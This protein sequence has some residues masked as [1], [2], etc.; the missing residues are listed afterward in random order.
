MLFKLWRE[1]MPRR[2][3]FLVIVIIAQVVQ[4]LASLW[5]PTLNADIINDGIVGENLALIW[6]LGGIMLVATVIQAL[7]MVVSAYFSGRIAMWIGRDVRQKV[8][9]QVLTFSSSQMHRFGSA[10]LITRATN[11]INQ[12]QS[13]IL[14]TFIIMIQAPIMG[15]GAVIMAVSLD[16][17]LS[18]L[19]LVAVPVLLAVVGILMHFMSPLFKV[20]QERIDAV[21]AR[22]RGALSGVRIV[23]AF[24]RKQFMNERFDTANRDLRDV[25]LRLGNLFALMI[26][27][28]QLIVMLS[29]IGVIWFGA[30]RYSSGQMEIGDIVAFL[31]YLM[32][33]LG[34]V[35]MASFMFVMVPRA[36]VCAKRLTEV[37][38]TPPE[39]STPR[40]PAAF[41]A[42]PFTLAFKGVSVGFAGASRPLLQ[43]LNFRIEP[44]QSTAIIGSTGSGKTSLL[45]LMMR[46]LDPTAG[47]ITVNGVDLRDL[48]LDQWHRHIAYV[49]QNS[50]LFSGTI[51]ST[52]SGMEASQITDEVREKV[53]ATL[54]Q[55]QAE[56]F[57]S[58]LDGGLDAEV[59]AGGKNFSGG[60]RQRLSVARALFRGSA[61]VFLDDP[62]SALDFATEA[63]LRAGLNSLEGPVSLI[64]VAQR[65]A[66]VRH[67]DQIIVLDEGRMVGLGTHEQL[68]AD[69]EAYQEIVESQLSLEEVP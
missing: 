49:P 4:C 64:F 54:R 23:R 35:M 51:A 41:P 40:T 56:E 18:L 31:T 24:G 52:V 2:W 62:F 8:Y 47:Q 43:D 67:A 7:G 68:Q 36:E 10:S 11:D 19:F 5:L 63:R 33:L 29:S 37:I 53:W 21:A 50:Y 66:S 48:D 45:R 69:C 57:V 9:D 30:G 34:A 16:A 61:L 15:V 65:I 59:S 26:P 13:V 17:P 55:A 12:V 39:I 6:K 42:E 25:A 58:A 28:V 22:I 14:M 3:A 60:Q 46:S 1:H 44:G 32:Q 38:S 27:A 20:Q